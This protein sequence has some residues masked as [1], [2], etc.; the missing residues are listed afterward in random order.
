MA[1]FWLK[2]NNKILERMAKPGLSD[3]NGLDSQKV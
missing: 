3:T 2:N 1:N